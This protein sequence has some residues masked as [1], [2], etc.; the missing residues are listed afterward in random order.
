VVFAQVSMGMCF[1]NGKLGLQ[2]DDA[3]ARRWYERAARQGHLESALMLRGP[4]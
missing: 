4:K 1:S 3:E 2:K